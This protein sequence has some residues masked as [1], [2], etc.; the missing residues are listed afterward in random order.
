MAMDDIAPYSARQLLVN[1]PALT[2]RGKTARSPGAP[3]LGQVWGIG[4]DP[5]N[6]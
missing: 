3:R 1:T 6:R 2:T 5:A 4:V